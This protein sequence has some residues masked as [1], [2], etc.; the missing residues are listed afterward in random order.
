MPKLRTSLWLAAILALGGLAY[1]V[2]IHDENETEI[3]L[4]DAPA[5]VQDAIRKL[6]GDGTID[7]IERVIEDGVTTY[8]VEYDKGAGEREAEF[9]ADG[10]V[11]RDEVEGDD[12]DGDDDRDD[13]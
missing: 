8:E 4:E 5:D 13:D 12:D 1:A 7:E 3:A 2:V 9:A 10:E 6:V 11:L